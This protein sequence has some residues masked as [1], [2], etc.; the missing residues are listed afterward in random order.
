VRRR[1][2]SHGNWLPAGAGGWVGGERERTR[3]RFIVGERGFWGEVGPRSQRDACA[4]GGRRLLEKGGTLF[5]FVALLPAFPHSFSFYGIVRFFLSFDIFKKTKLL[6]L[7]FFII[8]I[9]TCIYSCFQVILDVWNKDN[10]KNRGVLPSFFFLLSSLT[11]LLCLIIHL[12]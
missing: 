10:K 6:L 5:F 11:F 9:R 2:G 4:P 1:R 12:I 7:H 3:G 8:N